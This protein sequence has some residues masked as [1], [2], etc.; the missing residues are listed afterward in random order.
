MP[1]EPRIRQVQRFACFIDPNRLLI[2]PEIAEPAAFPEEGVGVF[3]VVGEGC[4]GLGEE[5][6][7]LGGEVFLGGGGRAV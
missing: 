4:F 2:A 5:A 7:L 3:W 6:G 1:R